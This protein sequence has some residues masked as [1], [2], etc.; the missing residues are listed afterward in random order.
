MWSLPGLVQVGVTVLASVGE[1]LGFIESVCF[2][3]TGGR[4]PPVFMEETDVCH[5]T[6]SVRS[7]QQAIPHSCPAKALKPS[8]RLTMGLQALAGTQSITGLADA[9]DV[10]RKYVYRQAATAQ[11]ALQD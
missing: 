5:L 8:Q 9:F 4:K 6:P 10:S 2:P 1:E 11:A 7:L 3:H